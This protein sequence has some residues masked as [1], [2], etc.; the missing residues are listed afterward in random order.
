MVHTSSNIEP[1]NRTAR[2]IEEHIVRMLAKDRDQLMTEFKSLWDTESPRVAELEEKETR[3]WT[4]ISLQISDVMD[5]T[6]VFIDNSESQDRLNYVDDESPRFP[7][8]LVGGNTLSRGLTLEGLVSSYFLRTSNAYDSLMQMGR[9]FGYRPGYSDLQRIWMA[10]QK[11]YETQNWFR[12]LSMVEQEIRDQIEIYASDG[13]SPMQLGI[14]IK[15]LPGMAITARAKNKGDKVQIGY[16]KTRQQTILFESDGD[17]QIKN[18]E[19][20]SQL[21]L[22]IENS[23]GWKHN[24]NN[25]P[26]ALGVTVDLI[27]RFIA[28]Y[29]IHPNIRTLEPT[30]VLDYVRKLGVEGELSLWNVVVY[31]NN[32]KAAPT[33][34]LT[35]TVGIRMANRSRMQEPTINIKA[36]ISLRDMIADKPEIAKK[37]TDPNAKL[38]EAEL[39]R[40]RKL[41]P[42]LAGKGVLGIYI[43]DKDSEPQKPSDIRAKLD[44]QHHLV[45]YFLVFPETES[46]HNVSYEAPNLAQIAEAIEE[47]TDD[48]YADEAQE[49]FD[50]MQP[51]ENG[52][53]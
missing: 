50:A 36:L 28:G 30:K 29:K 35:K 52:K 45:G 32:K 48:P 24:S 13:L 41:D 5:S 27:S 42:E 39:W 20:V 53:E 43:I 9:W 37:A 33:Y 47:D 1:H 22:D 16:G 17:K 23:V 11:P 51:A 44:T 6:K 12:E 3:D 26:V 40:L 4:K 31:S 38:T 46:K 34:S 49:E 18:L 15:S 21:A 7:V 10:N 2:A 19:L 8:I 14:R 25:W